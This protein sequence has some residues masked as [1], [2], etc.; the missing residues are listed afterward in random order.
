MVRSVKELVFTIDRLKDLGWKRLRSGVFAF[1]FLTKGGVPIG[2]FT[3]FWGDKS[4]GKSSLA[5]R[6]MGNFLREEERKALYLDFENTFDVEWCAKM[7]GDEGLLDRVLVG[8]PATL[9]EGIEI[10]QSYL[11]EDVGFVVVDSLASIVSLTELEADADQMYVGKHPRDVNLFLRRF[12]PI[13]HKQER[14][15][16]PVTVI[17]INQV[18]MGNVGKFLWQEVKPGGRFQDALVSLDVKFQT[19]LKADKDWKYARVGEFRFVIEKNKT[20]GVVKAPGLYWMVLV[21]D[22]ANKAGVVLDGKL[23]LGFLKVLGILQGES[24]RYVI[25]GFGDEEVFKTQNELIERINKDVE[26][27]AKLTDFLIQNYYDITKFAEVVL[28]F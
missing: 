12:F 6:L 3:M 10:L 15:G 8:K 2:K 5:L 7:V 20:G 27:K 13:V 22:E 18:R 9:E 1:D 4:T 23:V 26:F 14:E 11:K 21:D 16:H 24:G 19:N 25:E 17:L 28:K